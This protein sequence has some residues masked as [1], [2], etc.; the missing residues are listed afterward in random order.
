MFQGGAYSNETGEFTAPCAGQ[1]SFL[2]SMRTHQQD[3][4][5]YVEGVI[6]HNGKPMARTSVFTETNQDHYEQ[7]TNGVVLTL[8]EG[9]KVQVRIQ[10]TSAGQFYGDDWTV[11][12]GF[13]I[14]P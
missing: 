8:A 14:S 4:S 5:G 1:Y 12:S 7:A 2:L 10:T 6:E 13:Y 3:D 9:D 11:F